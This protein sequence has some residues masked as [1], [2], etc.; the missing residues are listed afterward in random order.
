MIGGVERRVYEAT[1]QAVRLPR[2]RRRKF[3]A[4]RRSDAPLASALANTVGDAI[5]AISRRAIQ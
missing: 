1:L 4:H 3:N 2:N 5:A